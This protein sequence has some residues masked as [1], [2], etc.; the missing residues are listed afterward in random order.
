MKIMRGEL[1]YALKPQ[2]VCGSDF[3]EETIQVLRRERVQ[4]V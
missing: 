3:P 1:H 2:E 4:A